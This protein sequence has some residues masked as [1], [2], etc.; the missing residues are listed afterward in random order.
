LSQAQFKGVSLAPT[1][2]INVGD[3]AAT[4]DTSFS[5]R[6][7]T[8]CDEPLPTK[9]LVAMPTATECVPC[10]EQ[11]GDVPKLK[12]YD[13]FTKDGD[14]VETLFTQNAL[15][16]AQID[17]IN[18]LELAGRYYDMAV[19]DDSHL[20]REDQ[21]GYDVARHMSTEFE[22]DD[23]KRAYNLSEEGRERINEAQ[24][25][26]WAKWRIE[27]NEA[28]EVDYE[29]FDLPVPVQSSNLAATA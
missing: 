20:E 19:G 8:V 16:E 23:D 17:Q 18:H 6:R 11:M 15:I 10:L 14:R 26:R 2:I 12:R 24:Q 13:E 25:K 21:G 22:D 28:T 29:L 1:A 3:S 7:C 27:R 5:D 4:C 9:R